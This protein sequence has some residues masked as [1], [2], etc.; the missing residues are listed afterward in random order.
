MF[1]VT[2][3]VS[4]LTKVCFLPSSVKRIEEFCFYNNSFEKVVLPEGLEMFG[5]TAFTSNSSSYS[6]I[7]SFEI[8]SNSTVYNSDGNGFYDT[9]SQALLYYVANGP[10]CA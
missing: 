10:C 1:V 8:S 2:S 3:T 9:S 7:K 4:S 6:S 5:N